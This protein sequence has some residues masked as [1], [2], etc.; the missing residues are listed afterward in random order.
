[1]AA[2]ELIERFILP[3]ESLGLRYMVTGAVA[4]MSY[5]EPRLT[6]DVDVVLELGPDD[7]PRVAA[8][9]AR[10]AD[11]YVPPVE[12][13]AAAAGQGAGGA[14]NVIHPGHALKADFFVAGDALAAWGLDHRRREPM[15]DQDAGV[16]VAPPEYVIVRK[17]EYFR[18]GASAKHLEDIRSMLAFG[19]EALD[20]PVIERHVARLGLRVEWEQAR[21]PRR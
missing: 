5:G 15:G 13:I 14:F 12:I 3:L 4:A 16:W 9:F 6:N 21:K 17:L 8:A 2:P 19:G 7:A 20:L 1:M 18:S 10:D 11:L